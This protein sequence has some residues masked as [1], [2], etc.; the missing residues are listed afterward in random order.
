MRGRGVYAELQGRIRVGG[1]LA[2][3]QPVGR[4]KLR[5]GEFSFAGVTLNFTSG[6]IGFDGGHAIDPTLNF[7]ATST[8][9]NIVA[10]LTISGTA[11]APVFTFSSVPQLPQD[12]VLAQ[13]LFRQSSASLSPFQMAS[14]AA[15]LAQISGVAPG[16]DPVNKVREGL[17]LDRLQLTNGR[18]GSGAVEAG[19]YVAPGVFVGARQDFSGQGTQATVQI[20]LTRGLTLEATVGTGGATSVTGAATSSD[21]SGTSIGLKYQFNY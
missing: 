17:G 7:V 16:F 6:E 19:S 20:D 9:G 18:S 1:T 21:P 10:T 8:N 12:E 5:R 11:S 2:A 15:A 13:L 3:P 14:A 4:F